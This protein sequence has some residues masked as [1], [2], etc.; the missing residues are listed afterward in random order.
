MNQ[1]KEISDPYTPFTQQEVEQRVKQLEPCMLTVNQLIDGNLSELI[2]NAE[3]ERATL[4]V[5]ANEVHESSFDEISKIDEIVRYVLDDKWKPNSF[6]PNKRNPEGD[7][8]H[9]SGHFE[10]L[11][12]QFPEILER[13][14]PMRITLRKSLKDGTDFYSTVSFTEVDPE[15]L[16]GLPTFGQIKVCF[17]PKILSSADVSF[18]NGTL[19]KMELNGQLNE[20]SATQVAEMAKGKQVINMHGFLSD[21]EFPILAKYLSE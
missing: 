16:T 10:E 15:V 1:S 5:S 9:E 3:F 2:E 12:V 20:E 14:V 11:V 7:I 19:R 18:V 4:I 17:G 21:L 8:E 13:D 6:L